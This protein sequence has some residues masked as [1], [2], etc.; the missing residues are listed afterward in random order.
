MPTSNTN[1]AARSHS[2]AT[3]LGAKVGQPVPND[4][5]KFV[6]EIKLRSRD[7]GNGI[8][9]RQALMSK[10]YLIRTHFLASV[11]ILRF[12]SLLREWYG[13][14]RLFSME[15][16]EYLSSQKSRPG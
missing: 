10:D 11:G 14:E 6:N 3:P 13:D 15:W 5:A 7:G 8:P 1:T 16:W 2:P 12:E 4:I 9:K